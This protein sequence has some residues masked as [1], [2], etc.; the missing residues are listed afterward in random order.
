MHACVRNS[1][2]CMLSIKFDGGANL[3]AIYMCSM[4]TPYFEKAECVLQIRLVSILMPR[5]SFV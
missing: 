4:V 2:G 3:V 5:Y 1:C